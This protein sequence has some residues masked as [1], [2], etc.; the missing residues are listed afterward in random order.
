MPAK[1]QDIPEIDL[2]KIKNIEAADAA[3]PGFEEKVRKSKGKKKGKFQFIEPELVPL[4]SKGRLYKDVTNDPDIRKGFI[5]MYPMTIK[6]E[7]ILS[8]PR[9]I[10]T[11]SATRMIID[12]CLASDIEAKDLLL[13]DSN[14]LLFYLRKISYGDE[15]KFDLTCANRACEQKFV[16]KVDI[17]NLAFEELPNTVKE[18]I[19]VEL[20]Y[21]K[22]TIKTM[23]P[24]LYNSEEIFMRNRNRKKG[25]EE[26]DKRMLD[27][28]LV[29]ALEVL[30]ED[31]EL[32][33]ERDWEEFFEALPGIDSAEIRDNTTFDTGIDD[34]KGVVC[35]YCDTEY[36]GT[37]PLGPEF[38]RF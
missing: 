5:R 28:F 37:I 8:T 14:F 31:K 23:L 6:E 11:G 15:Y 38:F 1:K 3:E 20:P 9:F 22:F 7:E 4:P 12:R 30:D 26:E 2:S 25:S 36:A 29:T 19:V 24:R 35:P 34:I 13:F 21:S 16:H 32:I 33:D 18:P 27:N 17:S 10:K